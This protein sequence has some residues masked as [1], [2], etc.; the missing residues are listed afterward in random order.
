MI[1]ASLE[2]M[3]P[4]RHRIIVAL[5][6]SEYAEIV[7]EHAL[8]QAARGDASDLHFIAVVRDRTEVASAK[9]RLAK[10][11]FS[12]LE[13]LTAADWRSRL[14]V[15]I[16]EPAEEIAALAGELDA[17]LLV[18]GHF[19]VHARRHGSFAARV[20]EL[21]ACPTLVVGIGTHVVIAEE[22]CPGCV[23]EREQSDG[24]RWFCKD[25]A[26][27]DRLDL[28]TRLPTSWSPIHGGPLW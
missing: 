14:H 21:V 25:H 16:G 24:E 4:R 8:D 20:L 3:T 23:A 26:S 27:P 15:R 1:S 9:L 13:N 6:D 2:A 17:D 18:L 12:G 11:V 7:L 22:A 5:D 10:L 28:T 19:G